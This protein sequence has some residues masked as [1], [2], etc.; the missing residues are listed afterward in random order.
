MSRSYYRFPLRTDEPATVTLLHLTP[1][2]SGVLVG[3]HQGVETNAFAVRFN[4]AVPEV[5]PVE[6]PRR[7][8]AV[9]VRST[10]L[11]PPEQ[12]LADVGALLVEMGDD[13]AGIHPWHFAGILPN[14]TWLFHLGQLATLHQRLTLVRESGVAD[15]E[16]VVERVDQLVEEAQPHAEALSVWIDQATRRLGAVRESVRESTVLELLHALAGDAREDRKA[17]P[18]PALRRI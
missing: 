10:G 7:E 2:E 8:M 12:V 17:R 3:L 16:R 9:P 1:S 18:N 5:H 15:D 13:V 11:T 14:E 6:P 4:R